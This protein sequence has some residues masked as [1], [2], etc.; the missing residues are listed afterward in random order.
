[1]AN[2]GIQ[3]AE[4][5]AFLRRRLQLT[6][7]EWMALMQA[8]DD[9][10][11]NIAQG[12]REA[13]LQD[14]LKAVLTAIEDGTTLADF[15]KQYER[16]LVDNGWSYAGNRRWHSEL[17]FRTNTAIATA[18]GRWDQ[19]QQVKATR[20]LLRYVT[21]HDDRVRPT[22]RLWHNVVLPVG[23]PFWNTHFPP[24]GFN[25]RCH[26]QS[27]SE[28]DLGRYG[29]IQTDRNDARLKVPPDKGWG[30][31]VG[32]IGLAVATKEFDST[33]AGL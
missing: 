26:V 9:A 10:S 7:A 30:Q 19:I 11:R 32:E 1:M 14:F 16:I 20:P 15:R 31:N 17:I 5:I 23:H 24:N 28:T 2:P 4:A 33:K 8:A 21:V 25:C 12:E 27:L 3:F 18:A 22:H 29:L 6:T 13:V